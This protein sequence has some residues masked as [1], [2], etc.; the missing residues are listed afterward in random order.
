MPRWENVKESARPAT[1]PDLAAGAASRLSLFCRVCLGEKLCWEI[2]LGWSFEKILLFGLC[3]E[4]EAIQSESILRFIHSDKHVYLLPLCHPKL[5]PRSV[6]LLYNCHAN[7]I[8]C[9]LGPESCLTYG[10]LE[11]QHGG[12]A[13][14]KTSLIT[15]SALQFSPLQHCSIQ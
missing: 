11:M 5:S 3:R 2:G 6:A 8:I 4:T 13:G 10:D 12:P 7:W 14:V 15:A 1:R 9:C